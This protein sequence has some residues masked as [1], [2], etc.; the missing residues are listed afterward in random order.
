MSALER[1]LKQE[2]LFSCAFPDIQEYS[3]RFVVSLASELCILLKQTRKSLLQSFRVEMGLRQLHCHA[4]YGAAKE[5]K[6]S[7]KKLPSEREETLL[8][9]SVLIEGGRQWKQHSKS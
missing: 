7:V 4:A 3:H 6:K 8:F 2:E 9:P 1:S 5:K